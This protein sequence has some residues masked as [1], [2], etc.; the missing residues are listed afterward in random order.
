MFQSNESPSETCPSGT[1][2]PGYGEN[3]AAVAREDVKSLSTTETFSEGSLTETELPE[4]TFSL[5]MTPFENATATSPS[6]VVP[7][8]VVPEEN[9]ITAATASEE[10]MEDETELLSG[11]EPDEK[12][13]NADPSDAWVSPISADAQT[14]KAGTPAEDRNI[15]ETT[16]RPQVTE[17]HVPH[18]YETESTANPETLFPLPETVMPTAQDGTAITGVPIPV[19]ATPSAEISIHDE[20]KYAPPS[21]STSEIP[22]FQRSETAVTSPSVHENSQESHTLSFG[23]NAD[24]GMSSTRNDVADFL[25]VSKRNQAP[26]SLSINETT[27]A[28]YPEMDESEGTAVSKYGRSSSNESSAPGSS[29]ESAFAIQYG[30]MAT[31]RAAV[32]SVFSV[33]RTIGSGYTTE[34]YV[35]GFYPPFRRDFPKYS[36]TMRRSSS[37]SRY[38]KPSA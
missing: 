15:P 9:A 7:E 17:T 32:A 14:L 12:V 37:E 34:P 38:S 19:R 13:A 36:P 35:Q 8:S 20:G 22:T 2:T 26:E 33:F 28:L 5:I 16:F 29:K 18:E 6:R 21:T 1:E 24:S 11:R 3:E 4:K 30:E 27:D 31:R 25:V 23:K 10:T